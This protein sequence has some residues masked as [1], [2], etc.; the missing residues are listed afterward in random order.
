MAAPIARAAPGVYD[1]TRWQDV[2]AGARARE[3]GKGGAR[4]GRGARRAPHPPPPRAQLYECRRPEMKSVLFSARNPDGCLL[5]SGS[6]GSVFIYTLIAN[7]LKRVALKF[8]DPSAITYSDGQQYDMHTERDRRRIDEEIVV[9][10]KLSARR[11]EHPQLVALLSAHEVPD[12][13]QGVKAAHGRPARPLPGRPTIVIAC[14]IA[15]G[16]DLYSSI[17][18]NVAYNEEYAR[19][20][21]ADIAAGVAALH[22]AHI[23]HR[24]LKAENILL[25]VDSTGG[26]ASSLHWSIC[27]FGLA[28]DTDRGDTRHGR[29]IGTFETCAPQVFTVGSYTYATDVWALGCILFTMVAGHSPWTHAGESAAWER[30]ARLRER[31]NRVGEPDL[32]GKG[33]DWH[34]RSGGL[35]GLGKLAVA[36]GQAL[37]QA[38]HALGGD[39]LGELVAIGLDQP[40]PGDIQVE[41]APGIA[42]LFEAVIELDRLTSCLDDL[43]AHHHL[44]VFGRGAKRFDAHL[45]IAH[46]GQGTG[47]GAQQQRAKLGHQRLLL[48]GRGFA[49]AAPDRQRGHAFEVD[50]GHDRLINESRQLVDVAAAQVFVLLD[51]IEH[52]GAEDPDE[53]VGRLGINLRC[54]RRHTGKGKRRSDEA[55]GKDRCE[56]DPKEQ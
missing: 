15:E 30:N 9:H 34:D 25:S 19:R 42:L 53:L 13:S 11:A 2:R 48:L 16:G 50:I 37:D 4:E 8:I 7:P 17:S 45:L 29:M 1:T 6:W 49:P 55:A 47:V 46:R 10:R 27:D 14:E 40:D 39:L 24:D 43:A 28:L 33:T 35:G 56:A 41:D 36:L 44:V 52:P 51:L 38:I 3:Y 5:G 20:A 32:S 21:F 54:R 23:V 31:R 12:S 26:S 22:A 18:R